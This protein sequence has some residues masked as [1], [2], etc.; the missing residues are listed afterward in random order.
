MYAMQHDALTSKRNGKKRE[1]N[2]GEM[3]G[4]GQMI[5]EHHELVICFLQER[6]NGTLNTLA[7]WI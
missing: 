6:L 3:T 7:E 5:K 2:T 1:E 4:K